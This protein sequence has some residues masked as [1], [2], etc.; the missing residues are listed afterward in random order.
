MLAGLEAAGET[1]R[2]RL[3]A[4]LADAE[5]TVSELTTILAQSQ[6]RISRHLRLLV[7]AGLVDRHR[8]GA[9]AFFRV[10]DQG[11]LADLVHDLIGR[12]D[13]LDPVLAADRSRL[14]QVRKARAD[15][16]ARYF[17]DH[18]AQWDRLRS[19][20]VAEDVVETAIRE[21]VGDRP[22]H[23]V[24]DLGTGTGR[25]LELVAPLADRGV[26]ID[27]SPAMLNLA[28][29]RVERAGLRHVQ[30]RQGDLYALPVERDGYDLVI[31][32]QVLHYLDDPVRALREAARVL[33]P[34]G[35]LLVVDFAPHSHEFL[36]D[37]HAHR[38]LG[39]GP[40]EIAGYLREAGLEMRTH[41]DLPSAA[42]GGDALTVSLWLAQDPRII[43]DLIATTREVA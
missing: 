37:Q 14:A 30:L 25:M 35:R 38:R 7:E 12:V 21:V 16:A 42:A 39:F 15:Q 33:R 43:S 41:R 11:P 13:P 17:A 9:W 23:A 5:L 36:R 1:S 26:G 6:P 3:L 34:G 32:H 20:H 19:L 22:L 10:S 8:E 31:L 18:A 40:D 29:T 27:Q 2:L 4:L 28:R 24:L